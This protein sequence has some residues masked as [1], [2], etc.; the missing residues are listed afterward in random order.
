MKIRLEYDDGPVFSTLSHPRLGA[1]EKFRCMMVRIDGKPFTV[2][3]TVHPME[4][5]YRRNVL[6]YMDEIDK[7]LVAAMEKM[8]EK[9]F[10]DACAA[11]EPGTELLK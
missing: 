9:I 7:A 8:F 1:Q 2:W 6:A 11:I 5:D 10:L 4:L 3:R